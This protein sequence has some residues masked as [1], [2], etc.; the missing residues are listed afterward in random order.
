M[1]KEK[2]SG[3]T[4]IVLLVSIV[5]IAL[6]SIYLMNKLYFKQSE[7]LKE[8]GVMDIGP[9]TP[10]N[11]QSQ[12]DSIRKKVKDIEKEQNDRLNGITNQMS[13]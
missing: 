10:Q 5:I 7:N 8:N 1:P 3:F 9:I 2:S 11:A 13:P 4:I 12:V 6:L